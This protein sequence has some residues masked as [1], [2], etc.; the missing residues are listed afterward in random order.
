MTRKREVPVTTNNKG[1]FGGRALIRIDLSSGSVVLNGDTKRSAVEA[2]VAERPL[3]PWRV[4]AS[5]SGVMNK[6]TFRVDGRAQPGWYCYLQD[7]AE[8]EHEL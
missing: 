8:M 5:R 6:V 2:F 3:G 7:P 1:S 4:V